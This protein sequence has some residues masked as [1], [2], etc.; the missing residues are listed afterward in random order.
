M[1]RSPSEKINELNEAEEP[2]KELLRK[3]G[4]TYVPRDILATERNRERDV[5]LKGRL[6]AAL[7]RLNPWLTEDQADRAIFKLEQVDAVGMARNRLVHEY[8]TYGMPLDV[9]DGGNRRTR[10]VHFFDFEHTN[11]DDRR[12][13][14]VVTTQLRVRRGHEPEGTKVEDDEKLVIPDLVLFVNGIPLVVIEAKSHTLIGDLWKARAVRRLRRYQEAEPEWH[15]RGA[16]DLFAYNLLCVGLSG[17][18]AVYGPIG[19]PENQYA[20]WKTVAPLT[21]D[22]LRSRFGVAPEGQARLVV[23]LLAPATLLDILRDYVVYEPE[24]GR[25]VKKLPRY[26]QYRAITSALARVASKANPAERGGVV[27]H[28]QGSGKSLTMIWLALKLR[29]EPRLANPTIAIVTDRTQLDEQITATFERCGFPTPERAA[30]T[31][32]LRDLL[33]SENG[34]TVMTTIQK[35]EEALKDPN[36]RTDPLNEADNVFVMVDEAHRTQYGLLAARMR[37]AL[38]NATFIGFTGTPIDKGF[39]STMRSFGP[40]IDTYTIPQSVADGA[41]VQIYYEARLPELEIMGPNK[42]GT[43]FD[44][45]F[46]DEPDNVKGLIKRRFA[47]KETLALADQRIEEIARDIATH[48]REHIRPNGFKAQV[49]APSREAAVK[50]ADYLNRFNVR[51][52]PIITT[53]DDDL[54]IF[55]GARELNH[56]QVINGFKDPSG[57]PEAL[58]VVDMLLTGFD[59]PV[60]QVLYLDR[61]LREHDLLQAIARVN[62]PCTLSRGGI[63]TEKTYG[64]VVDYWGVSQ[65][66][67]SALAE[68]DGVD[69]QKMWEQL[70]SDPAAV[71]DSAARMAEAYFKGRDLDDTWACVYLFAA[72]KYTSGDFKADLFEKFSAEYRRF[73]LLM[74]QLLPDQRALAYVDRLARLTKIRSYARATFRRE[75]ASVDWDD[76]TAKVKGLLDKR[77]DA[78]VVELMKPVS[79][80]D[81]AFDEKIQ[82]IPHD[83]ARASVME[84]AIRAQIK[85]RLAENPAFYEKLS[86]QLERVIALMRQAVIDA[87]TAVKELGKLRLEALSVAAL[88]AEQGL[89]E[90]SFAVYEL[91]ERTD[92]SGSAGLDTNESGRRSL[93]EEAA[94]YSA[95]VEPELKN[96]A[97][98]IEKVMQEGQSIVDWQNKE[99]VLRIMRRDIKRELRKVTTLSEEQI[100]ELAVS[101]VEIARRR[102]RS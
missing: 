75:N 61:G 9:D 12:N 81:D 71:I 89:T 14:Y 36:G 65:E 88:A 68:F 7:L 70:P 59:A 87:A 8:L 13:D 55:R 56:K 2:A 28:T 82:S 22:E 37:A 80:L 79:I 24:K 39:R 18:E 83:E 67:E 52:Y 1:A 85:E 43:L 41:T 97:L 17:A 38:P 100:N 23:G 96:T 42:L 51:T 26:Q 92:G 46:G 60:E 27:W 90:V 34:R 15:G 77:I 54:P 5:L 73:A 76:V 98:S 95:R 57:E 84:H 25:L 44:A 4:Y 62:R 29:G 11:P 47:N 35:F 10:S 91:L 74:D 6:R 93:R 31:R 48:Y 58:V 49:V 32:A 66:L 94:R 86:E 21:E 20:A 72:D 99:D 45:L 78:S 40:L 33:R 16:P 101:M 53:S 19:A 64:L 102:L 50:Y 30:N 3:L 69:I 63:E